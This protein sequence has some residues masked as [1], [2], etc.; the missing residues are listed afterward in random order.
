[1]LIKVL[2]QEKGWRF[3]EVIIWISKQSV[4][5]DTDGVHCVGNFFFSVSS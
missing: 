3:K 4:W 1:M 5:T 2:H